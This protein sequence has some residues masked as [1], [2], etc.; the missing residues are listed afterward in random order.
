MYAWMD[1]HKRMSMQ[2]SPWF[3]DFTMGGM[4]CGQ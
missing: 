3:E 4:V 1:R 2:D